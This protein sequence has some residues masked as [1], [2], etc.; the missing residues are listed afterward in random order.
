MKIGCLTEAVFKNPTQARAARAKAAQMSNAEKLANTVSDSILI[1][2]VKKFLCESKEIREE[3]SKAALTLVDGNRN[4]AME[5]STF[6]HPYSTADEWSDRMYSTYCNTFLDDKTELANA[7]RESVFVITDV[8]IV[9]KNIDKG[10]L[11]VDL[12]AVIATKKLSSSTMYLYSYILLGHAGVFKG[13]P[14]RENEIKADLSKVLSLSYKHAIAREKGEAFSKRSEDEINLLSSIKT[15]QI[16]KIYMYRNI[17]TR[18]ATVEV[19]GTREERNVQYWGDAQVRVNM[20]NGKGA[21]FL[22]FPMYNYKEIYSDNALT[23][24]K[25]ETSKVDENTLITNFGGVLNVFDFN[26]SDLKF[27]VNAFINGVYSVPA[28]EEIRDYVKAVAAICDEEDDDI[29]KTYN[30]NMLEPVA[31]MF[32]SSNTPSLLYTYVARMQ[33]E[34]KDNR[35]IPSKYHKIVSGLLGAQ[36]SADKREA[37]H[38]M[39]APELNT[40]DSNNPILSIINSLDSGYNDMYVTLT[41]IFI[42]RESN[43]TMT[44]LDMRRFP[45]HPTSDIFPIFPENN[46]GL[47]SY[48]EMISIYND[49]TY[50]RLPTNLS[51]IKT[52]MPF[53]KSTEA[54]KLV[55]IS[56]PKAEEL[57]AAESRCRKKL[58]AE[59]VVGFYKMFQS[60]GK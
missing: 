54:F 13:K 46:E 52:Y 1:P 9:D 8:Q 45:A 58:K 21:A 28:T 39:V 59:M 31:K 17:P 10:I 12:N 32:E 60:L 20:Q 36:S 33:Y 30:L 50:T 40:G 4:N 37:V 44:S 18:I 38:D 14:G 34:L 29:R 49:D 47:T 53:F 26:E 11:L 16:N 43:P 27:T 48:T 3:F 5:F 2:A 24:G 22:I 7:A 15:I 56:L 51:F 55:D 42:A 41:R 25:L 57:F 23:P 19:G 6:T 35:L